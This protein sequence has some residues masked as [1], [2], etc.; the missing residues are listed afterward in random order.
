L[1][2]AEKD[3]KKIQSFLAKNIFKK[4]YALADNPRPHGYKKM[5]S[6]ESDRAPGEDCYRI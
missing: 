2:Q 4:I 6:Y 3:I 1:N 5:N